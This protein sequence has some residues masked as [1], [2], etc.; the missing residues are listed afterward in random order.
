MLERKRTRGGSKYIRISLLV[1]FVGLMI[2]VIVVFRKYQ[3]VFSENCKIP[4]G[5]SYLYITE[6]SDF[7]QV[8]AQLEESDILVNPKSF[9]WV[10]ERKEYDKHVR[11]GRYK[12]EDGMSNNEL[13]NMLRSGSQ[14]PVMVIFNNLRTLNEL[15]GKVSHY[16]E[17]DSVE[18]LRHLTD[19]ETPGK[20]GFTKE[21]FKAMF[22]PNTYEMYW[23][24]SPEGFTDR[25]AKEYEIFWEKRDKKLSRLNMNRVEV[26]TLASIVDE[27]TLL[28]SENPSVAGV[29]INR[30]NIG[31][32]LQ[33]CPTL[34]YALDDWTI[35]RVLYEYQQ[36]ESPYNTYKHKGLPPGP[37]IIPSVSAID[38]V[39]N[40]EKHNYL[41][42]CAKADFSGT[43]AFART[44]KQH[45]QN[46]AEY[47]RELNRRKIY[48]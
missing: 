26:S 34:K 35:T 39:L 46:A 9:R 29:Y 40:Y 1:V 27:E 13:V 22:I 43:H 47:Q 14:E 18:M 41:Y 37:I 48:R 20:Y 30:L 15:A 24:T 31:M 33:S 45:N 7:D 28:D 4:D 6:G 19:P 2:S 3:S 38:G 17:C 44:L 21:T 11:P 5:H 36:V 12:L 10:A 32:A 8:M 42:M 16:L 23:T 25:M